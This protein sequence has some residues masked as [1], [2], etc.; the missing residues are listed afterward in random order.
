M[1]LCYTYSLVFSHFSVSL[2]QLFL[3][4]VHLLKKTSANIQLFREK[5]TQIVYFF[6]T[7]FSKQL[8]ILFFKHI[9]IKKNLLKS[10]TYRKKTAGASLQ[11]VP[12]HTYH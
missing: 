8:N 11:L 7:F 4:Y 12:T 2:T 10:D 1:I 5:T 9:E 3:S 6:Q